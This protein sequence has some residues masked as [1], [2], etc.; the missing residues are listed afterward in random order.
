MEDLVLNDLVIYSDY[1]NKPRLAK[2]TRLT[3]TLVLVSMK[4]KDGRI[5]TLKFNRKTGYSY[6]NS[7]LSKYSRIHKASAEE[8]DSIREI[9]LKRKLLSGINSTLRNK[10]LSLDTLQD[11][12]KLLV[13]RT[14]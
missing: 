8:V 4:D 1:S 7:S 14:A 13:E 11:I 3:K 10:E 12:A 5:Y 6:G 2:V 9:N